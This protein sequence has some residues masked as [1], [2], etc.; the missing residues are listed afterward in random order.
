MSAAAAA[1]AGPATTAGAACA[2]GTGM[3]AATLMLRATRRRRP[4]RS[5]SISV[6]LVSSSSSASS[7]TSAES[8]LENFAAA[9]SSGW[10]AM[11]FDP[12]VLCE[13]GASGFGLDA[14][15]GGKALDGEA[16]ALDAEA[17]E[18]GEGRARGVGV[19]AKALAGVDVGHVH[20]DRR[21]LHREQRVVQRDRGV[22]I[23]AGIAADA[24]HFA[25][26]RP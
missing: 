9:L 13:E 26:L 5:I 3:V 10:R 21:D 4:A 19:V 24:L 16:V 20:F 8:S 11:F 22:R 2:T 12:N 14:D 7:R 15:L 1:A 25:P 17:A 18:R 6:R 23:A